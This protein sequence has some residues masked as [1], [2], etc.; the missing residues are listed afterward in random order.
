MVHAQQLRTTSIGFAILSMGIGKRETVMSSTQRAQEDSFFFRHKIKVGA[1]RIRPYPIAFCLFPIALPHLR[2]LF[3]AFFVLEPKAIDFTDVTS[4]NEGFYL[5]FTNV[6]HQFG[7]FIFR[8]QGFQLDGLLVGIAT[9][10]LI[11]RATTHEVV[12]DI[13]TDAVPILGND[14]DTLRL[15]RLAVK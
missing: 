2:V 12:D 14:A 5:F 13:A 10:N 4:G 9:D 7:K 1:Y 3:H 8:E 11:Q 6:F 15:L